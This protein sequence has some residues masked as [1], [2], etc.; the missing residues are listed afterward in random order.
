MKG[1]TPFIWPKNV[2]VALSPEANLPTGLNYQVRFLSVQAIGYCQGREVHNKGVMTPLFNTDP[3]TSFIHHIGAQ[4]SLT[5]LSRGLG[6][7]RSTNN[8]ACN[9]ALGKLQDSSTLQTCESR[10]LRHI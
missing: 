9:R 8:N 4:F 2:L 6:R 5:P 7:R 3:T 10:T 1:T